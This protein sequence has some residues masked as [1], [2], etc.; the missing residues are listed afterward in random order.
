LQDLDTLIKIIRFNLHL[1]YLL[2]E[3][4]IDRLL[5]YSRDLH[6]KILFDLKK[7][8]EDIE[9]V[10]NS[11]YFIISTLN[12]YKDITKILL[13]KQSRLAI[14]SLSKLYS[15][16]NNLDYIVN[17]QTRY[18]LEMEFEQLEPENKE[19]KQIKNQLV[20]SQHQSV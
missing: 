11:E 17:D 8:S 18:Q 6:E 10:S 19:Y 15:I 12:Y 9:Y 7:E 14:I 13:E 4:M 3:E 1:S 2:D 5:L 20:S 16:Y